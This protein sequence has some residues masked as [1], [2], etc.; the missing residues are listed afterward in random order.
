MKESNMRIVSVLLIFVFVFS[1]VVCAQKITDDQLFDTVRRKLANDPEVKGGAFQVDVKDGVVTI[2]GVVEKQKQK[3]R[4]ESL[5]K[6]TKGV[7]GVV[8]Q[9]EVKPAGIQ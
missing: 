8:N 1:M 7:T 9:L 6:K 2:K 5:T 3:E 4:A